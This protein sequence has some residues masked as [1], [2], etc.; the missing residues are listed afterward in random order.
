[1]LNVGVVGPGSIADHRLAPALRA[2]DGARLWSVC[3][4]D[5]ARGE[6]FAVRH[7]AAGPVHADLA[8]L[9]A[10]PELHAVVLA[11]PDRLHASQ[12]IAAARAG[13][14]V[15]VEKPMATSVPEAEAMIAACT[16]ADVRLAVGYHLRHHAGLVALRERLLAGALGRPLHMRIAW[17]FRE[18]DADNW[19]GGPELARWW[20]LAALGTHAIDLAR[21]YLRPQCGELVRITA[22]TGAPVHG[23]PHDETA[24]VA[25]RFASGAT[26][27]ILCSVLFRAPRDV[28]VYGD[29]GQARAEE[30]LGPRGGGRITIDGAELPYVVGDPYQGEL[31]EFIDAI[32]HRRA[33]AVDGAEG[34]ANVRLLCEATGST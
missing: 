19:R 23:G 1:M 10:D 24:A 5:R 17:S 8:T 26:A 33:P 14:H 30:V 32:R 12:A 34:L 31:Q 3:S 22:L 29:A 9:L 21:W 2:V 13:K 16:A 7:G 25:L 15:F 27:D 4:R 28:E 6:A 20:A 18:R 11:T